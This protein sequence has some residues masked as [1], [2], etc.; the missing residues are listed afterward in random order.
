MRARHA[1]PEPCLHP[2]L[3]PRLSRAVLE[4]IADAAI[5]ELDRRDGDPDAEP[6]CGDLDTLAD[7]DTLHR[8]DL[9]PLPRTDLFARCCPAEVHHG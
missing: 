4:R 2:A 8:L 5:A 1:T 9:L 7:D 6:N 3:L